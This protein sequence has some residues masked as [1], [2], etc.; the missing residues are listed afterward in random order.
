MTDVHCEKR[1]CL[2]NRHGWCKANG[3]HID[4]MCRSYAAPHTLI[5]GNHAR[6]EKKQGRYKRAPDVLK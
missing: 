4:R 2:N 1:H 5:R 3:I 6:V